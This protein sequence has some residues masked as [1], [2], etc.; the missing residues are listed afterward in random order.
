M[1]IAL[2]ID[3]LAT[4]GAQR[5]IVNLTKALS[6]YCDFEDVNLHYYYAV[7]EYDIELRKQA[8]KV[9]CHYLKEGKFFKLI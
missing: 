9:F 7:N 3:T 5:Q 8:E 2:L 1:K 4:G 6:I